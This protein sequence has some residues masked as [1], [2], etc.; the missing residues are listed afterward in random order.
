MVAPG[1]LP[2][3]LLGTRPD[4]AAGAP[5]RPYRIVFVCTGNI[6]R[7]PMAETIT[8]ALSASTDLG[9]GNPLGRYLE[10]ASAGMGSWHTG[11]PMDERAAAALDRA[12]VPREGHAARQISAGEVARTDLVVA[13]DR[14]HRRALRA[15]GTPAARLTLLGAYSPGVAPAGGGGAGGPEGPDVPDPYYGDDQDFDR[16]RDMIAAACAGLVDTLAER[17]EV[18]RPLP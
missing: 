16:C 3:R 9:D 6:C 5:A 14:S 4:G 12:G 7:S 2:A 8:R 1:P 10:L 18:V 17:W 11:D 13:L 15:L